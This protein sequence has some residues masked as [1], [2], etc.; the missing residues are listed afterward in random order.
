MFQS[1]QR[2]YQ[3]RR[4]Q[5]NLAV[6]LILAGTTLAVGAIARASYQVVR[7][8]I[9]QQLREKAPIRRWWVRLTGKFLALILSQKWSG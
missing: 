9:L 6:L 8:L 3:Q 2:P 4:L 7:E 1:R 5:R